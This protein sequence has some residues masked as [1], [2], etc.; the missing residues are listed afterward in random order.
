MPE[1]NSDFLCVIDASSYKSGMV[2]SMLNSEAGL[3][4][5]DKKTGLSSDVFIRLPDG[6]DDKYLFKLAMQYGVY[7]RSE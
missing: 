5:L 6:Y 2:Y 4:Y 7:I 1:F 3:F